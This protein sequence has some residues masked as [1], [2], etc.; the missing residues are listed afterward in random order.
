MMR[1]AKNTLMG[2]DV[3]CTRLT[4]TKLNIDNQMS[5]VLGDKWLVIFLTFVVKT[6]VS[7]HEASHLQPASVRILLI[8]M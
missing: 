6:S 3:Y 7:Y 4:T 1:V 5:R 2:L 8:P